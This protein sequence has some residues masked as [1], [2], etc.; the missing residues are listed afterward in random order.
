MIIK[1]QFAS[2]NYASLCHEA[3]QTLQ[4]T[5]SSEADIALLTDDIRE[6]VG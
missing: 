2:D 3:W 6:I 4:E 5:N 1:N